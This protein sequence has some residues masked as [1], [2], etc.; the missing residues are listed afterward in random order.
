MMI[1]KTIVLMV[2]VVLVSIFASYL[3]I[4]TIGGLLLL[5][6]GTIR[7]LATVLEGI[8][9]TVGWVIALPFRAIGIGPSLGGR[10]RYV[11]SPVTL[12]V[13]CGNL[14]CSCEN[15]AGARFCRRCG[16]T[17]ASPIA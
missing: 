15:P 14:R 4:W 16:R 3:L 7:L 2:G 13:P 6:R 11:V 1:V 9:Y 5:I 12:G 8:G 10:S 17:L